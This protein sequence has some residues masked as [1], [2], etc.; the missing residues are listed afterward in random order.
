MR[1]SA[2][3][4]RADRQ[5][6]YR[7]RRWQRMRTSILER[8]GWRCRRCGKAGRLEVDHVVPMAVGGDPWEPANLQA[9]CRGCHSAKTRAENPRPLD[10]EV[11][12][13]RVLVAELAE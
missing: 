6:L 5:R 1:T 4:S 9:L 12:A 2:L 13:W 10:P 11:E 8:D 3:S 7:S